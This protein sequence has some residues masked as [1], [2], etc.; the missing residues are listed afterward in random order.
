MNKLKKRAMKK[1]IHKGLYCYRR[2]KYNH[3]TKV[4]KWFRIDNRY[5]YQE[6]GYC[7]YLGKGD[8]QDEGASLLWDMCKEC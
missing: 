5:D 1:W 2:D 8:W 6:D 4:C 7:V 3:K